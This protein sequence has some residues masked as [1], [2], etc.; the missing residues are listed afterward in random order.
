MVA[1]KNILNRAAHYMVNARHT[2]GTGWAF[3]KNKSFGTFTIGYTFLKYAI[4]FPEAEYFFFKS[5]EIQFLVFFISG[6]VLMA[7]SVQMGT[8]RS[9]RK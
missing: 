4:L 6:H 8:G 9:L 1:A 3:I 2:I 7:L 5:R